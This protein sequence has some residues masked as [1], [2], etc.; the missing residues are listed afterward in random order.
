[1]YRDEPAVMLSSYRPIYIKTSFQTSRLYV[2]GVD[3]TYL[4]QTEQ[5]LVTDRQINDPLSNGEVVVYVP[6]HI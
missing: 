5:R 3:M 6:R 4:E 1:M 2:A